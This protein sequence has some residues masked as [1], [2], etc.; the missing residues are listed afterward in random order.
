MKYIG[1]CFLCML[2]L[3]VAAQETGRQGSM[4]DIVPADMHPGIDPWGGAIEFPA[5]SDDL[6]VVLRCKA[7][8]T[9]AGQLEDVYCD[10]TRLMTESFITNDPEDRQYV[11]ALNRA[12]EAVRVTPATIEGQPNEVMTVFSFLFVREE[13][14][15]TI[16]L[17]QNQ[18]LNS[19]QQSFG[20]SAPQIYERE[21]PA[22]RLCIMPQ[23]DALRYQ[24]RIDGTAD[25]VAIPRTD[26]R[27]DCVDRSV[28]HEG[29]IPAQLDGQPVEAPMVIRRGRPDRRWTNGGF[30]EGP[31]TRGISLEG[32]RLERD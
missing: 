25:V 12:I 9:E 16:A 31:P 10:I 13:G 22:R 18:L 20:Y 8:I 2:S 28:A 5:G 15:E 6:E 23:R 11:I 17:F 26:R 30:N 24:V 27:Q 29:F 14:K 7:R 3:V 19:E 4:S 1:F 32:S 21:R